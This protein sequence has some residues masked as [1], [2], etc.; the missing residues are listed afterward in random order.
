MS[1]ENNLDELEQELEKR[2]CWRAY[3][4][5]LTTLLAEQ[6]SFTDIEDG[7][8]ILWCTLRIPKSIRVAAARRV[9]AKSKPQPST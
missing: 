8:L 5:E 6:L 2:D 9:L 7:D 4:N 1:D 3:I